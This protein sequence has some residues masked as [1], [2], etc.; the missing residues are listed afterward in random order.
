MGLQLI[1]FNHFKDEFKDRFTML[2]RLTGFYLFG[3]RS[4]LRQHRYLLDLVVIALFIIMFEGFLKG[5]SETAAIWWVFAVLGVVLNFLTAPLVFNQ[6]Q[7]N[8]R[9]FLLSRPDGRK[10]MLLSKIC[11]I[12]SID[13][14]W[15]VLFAVFYGLRFP[16]AD[17]FVLLLPRL[18][19]IGMLISINTLMLSLTFSYRPQYSWLLFLLIIL[20]FIV[21]KQQLLAINS[22]AD[23]A[24]AA[25]LLLPP[26]FELSYFSVELQTAGW[27]LLFLVHALL[28]GF[29]FWKLS[30]HLLKRKDFV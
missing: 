4:Y 3:L 30:S 18:L 17:Y 12:V 23:I 6:E 2:K 28:Y 7:G 15:V 25:A 16:S 29:F 21:N 13:L 1:G 20:G 9:S 22:F 8:A 5:S 14:F 26:Y 10:N 19:I 24:G 27:T 11:L